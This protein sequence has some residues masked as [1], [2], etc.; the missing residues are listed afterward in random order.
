MAVSIRLDDFILS[1][2]REQILVDDIISRGHW[3]CF[4][5]E[6]FL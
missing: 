6:K 1:L 3:Y 4:E 2:N 5:R